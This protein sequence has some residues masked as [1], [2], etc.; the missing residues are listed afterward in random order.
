MK[1]T[2]RTAA[3]NMPY[4]RMVHGLWLKAFL[5]SVRQSDS[6]ADVKAE[7]TCHLYLFGLPHFDSR[8]SVKT[9]DSIQKRRE[10]NIK[11]LTNVEFHCNKRA[12]GPLT[13]R[14]TINSTWE[15]AKQR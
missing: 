6:S 14:Q 9:I 2:L 15:R 4:T 5:C 1:I 10:R 8:R 3:L 13:G 12:C 11:I 7:L